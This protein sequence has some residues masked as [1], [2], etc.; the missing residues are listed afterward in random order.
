VRSSCCCTGSVAKASRL[1]S[2][3]SGSMMLCMVKRRCLR[4]ITSEPDLARAQLLFVTKLARPKEKGAPCEAP[5][6]SSIVP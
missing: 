3:S 2:V 5:L 1:A 6:V 4:T